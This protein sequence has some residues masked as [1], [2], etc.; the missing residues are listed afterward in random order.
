MRFDISDYIAIL[1]S[2]YLVLLAGVV[3]LSGTL[4]VLSPYEPVIQLGILFT[5]II[6][7]LKMNVP[8]RKR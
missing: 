6:I 2:I 7:A 3:G 1:L 4:E 8:A 5:L